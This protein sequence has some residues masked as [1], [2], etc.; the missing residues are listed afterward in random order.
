MTGFLYSI[1]FNITGSSSVMK[2][3]EATDRLD[4]SVNRA[5]GDIGRMG[6]DMENTGRRGSAAFSAMRSSVMGWVT[7]LG[8]GV[9]LL[10]SMRT[11][12]AFEGTTNAI[13][14]ASGGAERGAKNIEFLRKESDIMGLSLESSL[15][16]FKTLSGSMRG[17]PGEQLRK[18][19]HGVA[20]GATAMSLSGED[21]NGVFLALGQIASKG[22]VAAEELRGQI[23]ERIP[24]AF[25]IAA[26]AMNVSEEALNK[27]LVTGKITSK[28]F[29]PK[30]AAQMEKE[31]G[32]AVEKASNSATAN[33]NRFNNA[34]FNL[35]NTIGTKLLPTVNTFINRYFIPGVTWIGNHIHVIISLA[36]GIGTVIA[37]TKIWTAAQWLLNAAI[38]ANPIGLAIIAI[39][40]LVAGIVYAWKELDW[41]RGIVLGAWNVIE[42]F[43]NYFKE[44]FIKSFDNF[45]SAVS[46]AWDEFKGFFTWLEEKL[47]MGSKTKDWIYDNLIDPL[48]VLEG[49]LK[50]FKTGFNEG[51]GIVESQASVVGRGRIGAYAYLRGSGSVTGRGR[52]GASAFGGADAVEN[53][54]ADVPGGDN[55]TGNNDLNITKGVQGITGGGSKNITIN[56]TKLV[57]SINIH[58]SVKEAASDIQEVVTRVLMQTLNT[59]NQAQ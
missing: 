3:V 52:F 59:A 20:T 35:K 15:S 54:F 29:L 5:K 34:V 21:A 44:H 40:A 4:R 43:V 30:F 12:A 19:F 2:A 42:P 51:M 49:I 58:S 23:G 39:A 27:L 38:S 50:R 33:F 41:F 45:T 26:R 6:G 55:N 11:A 56:V 48:G 13:A 1:A 28:D 7:S 8:I 14:F 22:T 57:E 25:G 46:T 24:G 10:G 32:G 9:A 53:A 18:I 36:T 17:V 47:N 16:G 37:I 31:F